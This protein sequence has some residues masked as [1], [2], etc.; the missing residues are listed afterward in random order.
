[1][2]CYGVVELEIDQSAKCKD[3]ESL[4]I[5]VDCDHVNRSNYV[6]VNG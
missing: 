2:L 3:N 1:V 6:H 5:D 4:I